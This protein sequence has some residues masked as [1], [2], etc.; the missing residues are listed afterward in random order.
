MSMQNILSRF[1]SAVRNQR[2]ATVSYEDLQEMASHG[3]LHWVAQLEADELCRQIGVEPP[4]R[5]AVIGLLL[6]HVRKDLA[7]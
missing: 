2:G 3:F 5:E 1:Q 7:G 4:S 6:D